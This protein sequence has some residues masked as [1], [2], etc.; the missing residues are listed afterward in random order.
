MIYN[1]QNINTFDIKKYNRIFA[2]GCSFTNYC[3]PTWADI[4][5][6]ENLKADYINRAMPGAGNS[7]ILAHLSQAI[8]YHNI[9]ADDLVTIMWSTFYR[10]DSYREGKWHIPG[11]I[12]SQ[13][14]IPHSVLINHLNDTRGFAIQDF[15][16]IDTAT[17]ML[18]G[19]DF[20]SIA[21]WGVSPSLQNYYGLSQHPECEEQWKD[22][23]LLYKD[24]DNH[25]L[26]DLL[27]TG[28][29]GEWAETFTFKKQDNSDYI[30]YHP[31]TSKYAE[32]LEKIGLALTDDTKQ[33]AHQCDEHTA[34]IVYQD[35]LNYLHKWYETL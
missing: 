2:F 31:K 6:H 5:A 23:E 32:Y 30:D 29:E 21:M 20:D 35:D 9:G 12:Y 4:I 15:A 7:F 14:D 17:K 19:A 18:D 16:I 11:N 25:I 13:Y 22:V 26:P 33:W 1:T 24:L 3:W 10:H 27:G 8:R 34:N 28:C